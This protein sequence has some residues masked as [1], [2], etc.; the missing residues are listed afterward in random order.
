MPD[1]LQGLRTLYLTINDDKGTPIAAANPV[2]ARTIV[3]NQEMDIIAVKA[4]DVDIAENQ[5]LSFVYDLEEKLDPG[6]YRVSIFTEI[7]ML[8]SSSI[9]LR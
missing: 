9:R 8:G 3:N 5:R 2:K 6:F 7:G 4:K 1:E